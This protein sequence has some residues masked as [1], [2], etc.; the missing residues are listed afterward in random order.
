MPSEAGHSLGAGETVYKRESMSMSK[1]KSKKLCAFIMCAVGCLVTPACAKEAGVFYPKPL[2]EKGRANIAKYPWA[3]GQKKLII[4]NAKPWMKLSDDELWGLMFG[5]T[6]HR[7]WMVL[8]DGC[9]PACGKPVPMYN[10]LIDAM[11]RPWKVQCPECKEFFPKNDFAA[12]YR[13]GLD[14]CGIFDPKR[15][16]RSLLINTEHPDP[17]GPLHGFGVDDGEGFVQGEKRWRFVSAYLIYG[18]W[19][20]AVLGG[21]RNLASAYVVSG[22]AKYARKAAILLDRVADLY[23]TFDFNTQADLYDG[24]NQG[25]GYVSVWHDACEE[26]RELAMGYDMIFDGMRDDPKLVEFLSRQAAEH[27]IENPKSSFA[28]IQRNIEDRILLDTLGHEYKI[29][30]NY[31]RTPIAKIVINATL[32]RRDEV[33]AILDPML[34]QATAVDGV[35]GEKG[36][37]DYTAHV[38]K[39]VANLLAQLSRVEPSFLKE[40]VKRHPRIHDMFRFHMDTWC[41]G[42]YY[43]NVGDSGWFGKQQ[44]DYLGVEFSK[45]FEPSPYMYAFSLS[46]SMF[47]FL[48]DLYEITG[49]TAFVQALNHA[50]GDSEKGLP[51]D[52][53]A[54]DPAKFE[55]A[56]RSV[57]KRV[58]PMPKLGSVNKKQWHI[59]IL[60]S[61]EGESARALWMEYDAWGGHGHANC[62][63]IGLFAKGLDLMPDF[64]YK[65]VN[66]GG[67]DSPRAV[68]YGKTAAHDTVTVDGKDQGNGSG[69]TKLWADGK[70]FKAIRASGATC[71]GGQQFDRSIALVDISDRDCYVL[72]VFRVVGGTDHAK[73][74]GSYFGAITTEGLS[75]K[76]AADYGFGAQMRNFMGDLSAKPG[77]SVDWKIQDEYKVLPPGADVHFRYTDLTRNAQAYTAEAWI[78]TSKYYNTA[79]DAWIPRIMVRRQSSE[80]P[81]ASTFVA[82]MA[83]YEKASAIAEIR[84]LALETPEGIAYPDSFAAV[85]VRLADGRR[86]L[87]ISADAENPLGLKPARGVIVQKDWS[88]RTDAELCMVRLSKDGKVEYVSLCNGSFVTVGDFTYRPGKTV[89]FAEAAL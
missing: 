5:P 67:W 56:V 47:T 34:E 45:G 15:A 86:D 80:A 78:S 28:D 21:I 51:Y 26:A 83:P 87:L 4:E 66:F 20:Q 11:K 18:Q 8:S 16:D 6:I 81:L 60:R 62:M 27:K 29:S 57:I 82:V 74:T 54:D 64:G 19:K 31:P 49:D 68:W 88:L 84:R 76:P 24:R 70:V 14:E 33:R 42:S 79:T 52:L 77:W 48:W 3:A 7:S 46:P 63:E 85:E 1:S 9:C 35:T 58:G 38:I 22:D 50:N 89:D 25:N 32:G 71:M 53:F 10:W 72:D 37:V 75:L 36:M 39:G 65:P 17:K 30:S 13:S 2:I 23:P 43:P 69:E 61:G 59:A 40:T 12:F 55:K 44:K 73:F 41:I